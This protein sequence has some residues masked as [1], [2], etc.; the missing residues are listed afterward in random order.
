M[1]SVAQSGSLRISAPG[2]KVGISIILA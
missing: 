1:A 2:G